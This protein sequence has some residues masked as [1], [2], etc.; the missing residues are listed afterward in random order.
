MPEFLE[1]GRSPLPCKALR[2]GV[3]VNAQGEVHPCTVYGRPLGNV[4]YA[5]PPACLDDEQ[6]QSVASAM[7]H[8]VEVAAAPE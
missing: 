6:L 5:L 4:L 2:A 7:R 1:T 8:L 3:F